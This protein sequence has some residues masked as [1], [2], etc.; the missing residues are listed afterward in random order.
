MKRSFSDD[1]SDTGRAKEEFVKGAWSVE[2]DDVMRSAVDTYG[3]DWKAVATMV[4]GRTSKQCRDRYKLKLDPS[5]N[6]GPWSPEEDGH[7]C[8]LQAQ[9]GRQWTKIAKLLP[10]RTENSVKSRFASLQ[11]SK[12]REW[13]D[14]EDMILRSCK[15]RDLSYPEIAGRYLTKRSEHAIQKRW[16]RLFMRDLAKRIRKEIPTSSDDTESP[17]IEQYSTEPPQLLDLL[18]ATPTIESFSPPPPFRFAGEDAL[19]DGVRRSARAGN[20]R[21]QTTSVQILQNIIKE[22]LNMM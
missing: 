12:T 6:H 17:Y 14:E 1:D 8:H 16:E 22:P 11:R 21:K 2:E 10:G 9:F 13:T 15:E 5:I 7:L 4:V 18:V 20:I 3:T 19:P